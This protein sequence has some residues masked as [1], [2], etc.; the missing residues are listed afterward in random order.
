MSN[1]SA[2]TNPVVQAV[3]SGKAPAGARMAAARGL[4]PLAHNELLEVL[5]ALR[6]DADAEVAD[7]AEKTLGEQEPDQRDYVLSVAEDLLGDMVKQYLPFNA[8]APFGRV[9]R[10]RRRR[11]STSYTSCRSRRGTARCGRSWA[12]RA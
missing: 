7:A 12:G 5:V 2:S 1:Q 8:R 4:L 10:L 3:L 11:R 6:A 9:C